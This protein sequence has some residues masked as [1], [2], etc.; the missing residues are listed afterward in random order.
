MYNIHKIKQGAR[1]MLAGDGLFFAN[2][3]KIKPGARQ[4]SVQYVFMDVSKT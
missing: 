4:I 3:H 1:W 2:I